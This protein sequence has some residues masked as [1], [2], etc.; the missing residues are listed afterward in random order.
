MGA[1]C[2][3]EDDDFT[4]NAL[5]MLLE[6]DGWDVKCFSSAREFLRAD[7]PRNVECI[8]TDIEMPGGCTGLDLLAKVAKIPLACPVIIMTGRGE[9]A[10][11]S[12]AFALGACDY[13]AKPFSAERLF[14]AI[15]RATLPA[16]RVSVAR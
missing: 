1:I 3:I 10:F 8:L 11:R 4:R 12:A 6:T 5:E 13:L 14:G 7:F 15:A 9:G 2:V 16:T